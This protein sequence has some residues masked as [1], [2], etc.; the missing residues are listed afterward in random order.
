MTLV[1]A[2]DA[3]TK[4]RPDARPLGRDDATGQG[5]PDARVGPPR[6]TPDAF[7]YAELDHGDASTRL[8]YASELAHRRRGIIDVPEQ[9]S[10]GDVI[11]RAVCEGQLL[12]TALEERFEHA[13]TTARDVQHVGALIESDHGAPVALAKR[14]CHHS[15]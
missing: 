11:E 1:E 8:Q 10:E 14:R 15:G 2:I 9:V 5:K 7:G 13:V 12:G 3:G 6:R 4:E